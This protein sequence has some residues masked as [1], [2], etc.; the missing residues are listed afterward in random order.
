MRIGNGVDFHKTD[1]DQPCHLAGLFFPDS[2]GCV[3]HSDG[4][5]AIHAICD[6]LLAAAGLGDLGELFG[7]NR[8]EWR[9]SDS[10]V[11][12]SKV[13]G[14]VQAAG[15]QIVNV[16]VQIVAK[17]PKVSPRRK[18][19]EVILTKLVGSPVSVSATTADGIGEIGS[20]SAMAAYAVALITDK[21]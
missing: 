3:G 6:S 1:P 5:V 21:N 15:F 18:E 16:T 20:G 14:E 4:D 9:D 12:L 7:V 13:V 19:A 11:F 10:K 8:P 2:A 17:A